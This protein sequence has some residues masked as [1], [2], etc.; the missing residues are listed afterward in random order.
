MTFLLS[1]KRLLPEDSATRTM[2]IATLINTAGSGAYMVLAVLY[3]TRII[4]LSP[5]E[6]GGGLTIAALFGLL[7]G[8]PMGH[9]GDRV[10]A[11]GLI[12]VLLLFGSVAAASPALATNFWEFVVTSSVIAIFDR[13]SAAVRGAL[14][15]TT[16]SGTGRIRARAYLRATTN[17]GITIG[18]AVAT[19]PLHFDTKAAYV[20]MILLNAVTYLVTALVLLRYPVS[21]RIPRDKGAPMSQVFRDRSYVVMTA[22]MSLLAVQYSILDVAV[23]LW[24]S[25]DTSAPR[26]MVSGVFVINTVVVVI[27]QVPVSR[28]IESVDRARRAIGLSGIV[29]LLACIAFAMA[30]GR[31]TAGAIVL[32]IV[33]AFI[34]VTGELMSAAAQFCL[35]QDLAPD[36]AQGQYQGLASTSFSLSGMLAPSII[37]FLPIGLGVPGWLILGAMFVAAGLALLPAVR[38][39]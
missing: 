26:W 9:L 39:A 10:G 29:F 21:P 18:A 12:V 27:A 28:R 6:V 37:A 1:P 16:V 23:P 4:G 25:R 14:I 24:V 36:H 32:L 33:A 30:Q 5:A 3:F 38:W 19:I 35:G 15:A 7:S 34:H 31:S 20:T 8:V 2:A 13:G 17:V 22:L 11:R